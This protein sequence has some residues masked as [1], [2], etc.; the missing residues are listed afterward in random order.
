MPFLKK[1]ENLYGTIGIWLINESSDELLDL[2]RLN[3]SDLIEYGGIAHERRKKEFLI[4]RLLI[5]ELLKKPIPLHYQN[6]GRPYL[7]ESG[8]EISISHSG[9]L[10]VIFLSENQIGIDVEET[11]RTIKPIAHKFMSQME[12]DNISGFPDTSAGMIINWCAKEAVFK[13]TRKNGIDF[14][15]QITVHPFMPID[16]YEFNAELFDSGETEKFRL[17]FQKAGNNVLVWCVLE[18]TGD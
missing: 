8:F 10:V 3:A 12:L 1:I 7:D 2:I 11:E 18:K 14:R 16:G 4:T 13:C 5:L 6:D 9:S 15:T 17:Q